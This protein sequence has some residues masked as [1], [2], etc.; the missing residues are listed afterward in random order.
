MVEFFVYRESAHLARPP[1]LDPVATGQCC[2]LLG[3]LSITASLSAEDQQD[4]DY[5]ENSRKDPACDRE[6][7]EGLSKQRLS[8]MDFA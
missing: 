3:Y 1:T 7:K 4:D 2:M 8:P 6:P 5:Q